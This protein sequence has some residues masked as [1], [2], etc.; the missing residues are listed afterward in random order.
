MRRA[1]PISASLAIW[2]ASGAS[3]E[4]AAGVALEF[5]LVCYIGLA[6]SSATAKEPIDAVANR[7]MAR[8]MVFM[9]AL[10]ELTQ[11]AGEPSG[12]VP[13]GSSE[14]NVGPEAVHE[15]DET[16]K[17]GGDHLAVVHDYRFPRRHPEHQ[18]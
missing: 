12:C 18:E 16:G 11:R 14:L 6:R 3:T 4:G 15:L 13:P 9:S 7:A 2:R 5:A 17:R 10:L 8:T 1:T